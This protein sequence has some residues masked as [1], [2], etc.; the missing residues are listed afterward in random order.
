MRSKDYKL[1]FSNS[2]HYC[3]DECNFAFS[4]L[5][6]GV[7][8]LDIKTPIESF[9]ELVKKAEL[10]GEIKVHFDFILVE[11]K[12]GRV[13]FD[14]GRIIYKNRFEGIMYHL[15]A[16]KAVFSPTKPIKQIPNKYYISPSRIY[17]SR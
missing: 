9:T 7:S 13:I 8:I 15:I 10:K 4:L 2:E 14:N 17:H 6:E 1:V 11:G 3:F 16:L 12:T 5:N